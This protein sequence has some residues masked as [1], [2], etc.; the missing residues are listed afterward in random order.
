M[1]ISAKM[2]RAPRIDELT[3][4][5]LKRREKTNY[6]VQ[7]L[8]CNVWFE[9]NRALEIF[10]ELD[11]AYLQACRYFEN[12]NEFVD[13]RPISYFL[14]GKINT[15]KTTL[16]NKYNHYARKIAKIEGR[17]FS[18]NDII[19]IDAPVGITFK[20]MFTN[21]LAKLGV[22]IP[23]K[24]EM[25]TDRVIEQLIQELRKRK[26]KLLFIDDIQNMVEI[27]Q[28][29]KND[30]FDGFRK[31]ANL[32]Q[33]RL[34]LVGLPEAYALFCNSNWIDERYRALVLSEWDAHSK[35]YM[36][37]LYSIRDAY[38]D[39]LQDWD[40]VNENGLMNRDIALFL[41]TLSGGRLG[42]LIQTIQQAAVHALLLNKTNITKEDYTAVQTIRYLIKDGQI[43]IEDIEND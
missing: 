43:M 2:I 17:H 22:D 26:V 18:E 10:D 25:P 19:I 12:P 42:K 31:I 8:N 9:Y 13:I 41:H 28:A 20:G 5:D 11:I 24:K 27:S 7:I 37:L 21:I 23:W 40:L 16:I 15:G 30:I 29:D 36:D 38:G 4:E 34:V 35:E 14:V 32:S 1:K 33:T 39:F 6:A 3:E